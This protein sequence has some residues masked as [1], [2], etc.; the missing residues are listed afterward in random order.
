MDEFT[1]EDYELQT[2][3]WQSGFDHCL[4]GGCLNDNPYKR[5]DRREEWKAGFEMAEEVLLAG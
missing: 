2:P 5:E 4:G 1:N 3:Y